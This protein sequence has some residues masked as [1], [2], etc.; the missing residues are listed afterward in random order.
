MAV[1]SLEANNSKSG[2][3]LIF[4]NNG[5]S[6]NFDANF[7]SDDNVSEDR[8]GFDSSIFENRLLVGVPKADAN[9]ANSGA[10]YIF[11]RNQSIW[12]QSKKI[13]PDDLSSDDEFGYAVALSGDL[14]FVSARQRDI[15]GNTTNAGVVYVFSYDG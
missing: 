8:F 10:A 15:D 11:E 7:T 1:K 4:E 5:T 14:A 13:S 6:W 9:G 3:V 2:K 12:S